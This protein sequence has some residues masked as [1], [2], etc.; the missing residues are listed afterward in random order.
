MKHTVTSLNTKKVI[1]NSLKKAMQTKPLSKI[2]VSEIIKDCGINRKTFYYHFEDI[3]ALLKWMFEEEAIEVLK[4]FDLL[5]DYEEAVNF[6]LD[7]VEKNQHIINC[8]Y[9]SIGREEMKHFFHAD[10]IELITSIVTRAEQMNHIMLDPDFKQFICEFYTEGLAGILILYI[11]SKD[12]YTR[13]KIVNYISIV[14]RPGITAI[15]AESQDTLSS[16][17][18][19]H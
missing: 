17:T 15:L 1:A 13:E 7:Y 16:E 5:V 3:Y 14:I 2:T 6:V 4:N 9:D 10:F 11:K 19:P 18:M 12:H 8:A